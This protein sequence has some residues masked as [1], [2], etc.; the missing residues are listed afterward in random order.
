MMPFGLMNA[1]A[2]NQILVNK[3][4]KNQIRR[5]TEVYV[6]DLLVKSMEFAQHVEDLREAFQDLRQYQMKL[7][8]TKCTFEVQSGKFIKFMV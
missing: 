2:T 3:M 7:N 5:N 1:G 4:F 6:N 8:S